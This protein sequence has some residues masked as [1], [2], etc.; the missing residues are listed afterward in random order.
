MHDRRL[1]R[2][3]TSDPKCV[4]LAFC[5]HVPASANEIHGL[6]VGQKLASSTR[7]LIWL[8]LSYLSN[9]PFWIVGIM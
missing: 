6:I 9:R 2:N 3:V 4:F 8:N 7:P 1:A 5:K